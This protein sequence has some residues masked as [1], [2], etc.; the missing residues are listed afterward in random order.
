MLCNLPSAL[1]NRPRYCRRALDFDFTP[2]DFAFLFL[3]GR[4]QLF[5]MRNALR[6]VWPIADQLLPH[7]LWHS[8]WPQGIHAGADRPCLI[9]QLGYG[10]AAYG[11]TQSLAYP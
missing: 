4:Q 6:H 9:T 7:L 11:F 3:I 5:G 8:P 2:V 1:R 10:I